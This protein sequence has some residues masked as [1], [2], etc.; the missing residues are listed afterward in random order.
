LP[1]RYIPPSAC[2]RN[3]EPELRPDAGLHNTSARKATGTSCCLRR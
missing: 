1:D 2:R 3:D